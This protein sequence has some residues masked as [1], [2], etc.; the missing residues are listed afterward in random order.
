MAAYEFACNFACILQRATT[1]DVSCD[2]CID[3]IKTEANRLERKSSLGH[4]CYPHAHRLF[5][6]SGGDVTSHIAVRILRVAVKTSE[7]R[8]WKRKPLGL[9]PEERSVWLPSKE[10]QETQWL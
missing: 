2:H 4:I 6:A 5:D 1:M 3:L 9:I 7:T 8:I 10:R